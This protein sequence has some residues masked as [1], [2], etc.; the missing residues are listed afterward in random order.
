MRWFPLGREKKKSKSLGRG[1]KCK[2]LGR[3][4][5]KN[6]SPLGGCKNVPQ[7]WREKKLYNDK[8][9]TCIYYLGAVFYLIIWVLGVEN[10]I[11]YLGHFCVYKF[12]D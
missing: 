6:V 1:E 2:P 9:S 11:P 4:Q 10:N 3:V 5:K 8:N 7:W 12:K